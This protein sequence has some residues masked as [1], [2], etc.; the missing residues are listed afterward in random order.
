MASIDLQL[1]KPESL[2]KLGLIGRLVPFAFCVLS[3]YNTVGLR[4][5]LNEMIEAPLPQDVACI[6]LE[7]CLPP[8][9]RIALSNASLASSATIASMSKCSTVSTML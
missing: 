5:L 6:A 4:R 9:R 1:E 2:P 7:F 3:I 8:G